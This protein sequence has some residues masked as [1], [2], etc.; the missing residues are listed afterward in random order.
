MIEVEEKGCLGRG[1][2]CTGH[3]DDVGD[4]PPVETQNILDVSCGLNINF[5]AAEATSG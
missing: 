1:C 3:I 4:G 2:L 5:A